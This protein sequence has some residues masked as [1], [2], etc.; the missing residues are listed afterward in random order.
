[1]TPHEAAAELDAL[2]AGIDATLNSETADR[3]YQLEDTH[4][5]LAVL[6]RQLRATAATPG[7]LAAETPRQ[8]V[9]GLTGLLDGPHADEHTT[10]AAWLA[11][12]A[13]RYLNYATGSHAD[14]G[15]TYPATVY[16]IT[17]SLA[18][19]TGRLPQLCGQLTRWL[20]SECTAGHLAD[21]H[22]GPVAPLTDRTRHHLDQ[23]ARH[24][25]AL[26]AAL[27][28]AQSAVASVH[29]TRTGARS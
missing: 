9:D 7:H 8:L 26:G 2:V 16:T 28:A 14:Q 15:L 3:Q 10:G 6:A 17:G 27:S 13:I 20:D 23:A 5:R 21:D 29:G 12:E 24:A 25:S 18:E 22:G 4:T 19:A 11:S 1:M